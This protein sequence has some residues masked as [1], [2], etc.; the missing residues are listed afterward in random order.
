MEAAIYIVTIDLTV[1]GRDPLHMP[2]I[3]KE[4]WNNNQFY[5]NSYDM[6]INLI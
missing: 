6:N 5:Y 1:V 4:L 3:Y 2:Y